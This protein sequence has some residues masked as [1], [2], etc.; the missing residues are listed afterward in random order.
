MRVAFDRGG[1][2]GEE[3]GGLGGGGVEGLARVPFAHSAARLIKHLFLEITSD[4]IFGL[5]NACGQHALF[6]AGGFNE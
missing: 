3:G 6:A 2:G 5:F 4:V 1:K